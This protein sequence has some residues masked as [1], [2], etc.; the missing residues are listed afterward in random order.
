[1]A[2]TQSPLRRCQPSPSTSPWPDVHLPY[3]LTIP[4]P[5]IRQYIAV[6]L[7]GSS[8]TTSDSWLRHLVGSSMTTLDSWLRHL[9]GSS[10][11][12]L[13]SSLRHLANPLRRISSVCFVMC[14]VP[15]A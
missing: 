10:M 8:M 7:V 12:T 15:C 14:T 13:Y 11:P 5:S 2:D 3:F 6:Y 9:V 4:T 1:Y